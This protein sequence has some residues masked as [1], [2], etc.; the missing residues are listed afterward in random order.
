ME[1]RLNDELSFRSMVFVQPKR[2]TR[3]RLNLGFKHNFQSR[4]D[5]FSYA[6]HYKRAIL[7]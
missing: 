6:K 3:T 4:F 1:P 7:V 5:V 2:R